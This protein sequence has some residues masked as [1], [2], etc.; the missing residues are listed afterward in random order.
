VWH[1]HPLQFIEHYRKCGWLA[2]S[3]VV[4]CI[5]QTLNENGK[6]IG[7]ITS[8]TIIERLTTAS[9]RR[10]ADL[11]ANLQKMTRKYGISSSRERLAHLF[12][13]LTAETGRLEFMLE[14]GG[15]SYFDKY[16]PGTDEGDRLGNTQP[17]DGIRFKGRG[18][19]QLTG[20]TNYESYGTYRNAT[21]NTDTTSNLLLTNAYDTCDASGYYWTSKQR[22]QYVTDHTTHRKKLI[23]LGKQGIN[24]WADQGTSEQ[25]A[26]NVTKC[27]NPGQ[28]AFDIRYQGFENAIYSLD[29]EITPNSDYKPTS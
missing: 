22:Y 9:S 2:K 23:P 15:P 17:G 19:I 26:H 10:P 13:Q 14:G 1:F 20:R 8:T 25:S 21:F 24:Y 6:E 28:V 12:G 29:D 3:E 27:I 11:H 5:R 16:E 7:K 4:R 18:L